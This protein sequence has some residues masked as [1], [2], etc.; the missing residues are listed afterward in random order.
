MS[1]PL[2]ALLLLI[3]APT[4][5]LVATPGSPAVLAPVVEAGARCSA[6]PQLTVALTGFTPARRGHATIVVSLRTADGRTAE[7][8]QV[9]VFPERAFTAALPQARR[10]GFSVPRGALRLSPTVI[11]AVTGD[12][13]PAAGARAIVGE[14]RIGPAPQERC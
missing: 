3:A 4:Q 7:L 8:G 13:G 14:A 11:V 1:A 12:G 10:F 2:P 9:A 6:N 5:S